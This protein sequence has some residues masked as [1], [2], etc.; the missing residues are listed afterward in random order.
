MKKIKIVIVLAF[1]GAGICFASTLS[2]GKE[3]ISL[4]L[5]VRAGEG[6][7]RLKPLV[8]DDFKLFIN[9]RPRG[10]AGVIEHRRSM[11]QPTGLGRNFILSFHIN[12]YG[13]KLA[14]GV[15]Y[16]VTEI[17]NNTDML[18]I[19]TPLKI[20][21]INV[22]RNKLKMLRD[23][24]TLVSRDCDI[25]NKDRIKFEKNL[26]TK[27]N[28]VRRV[29]VN[30]NDPP[31]PFAAISGFLKS[32]PKEFMDFTAHFLLPDIGKYRQA[33]DSLG[34]REGE[35]WCIH[36]Q[37]REV[38]SLFFKTR[39]IV[40]LI[41]TGFSSSSLKNLIRNNLEKLEKQLVLSGTELAQPFLETVLG[42]NINCSV[43]FFGSL[44]EKSSGSGQMGIFYPGEIL[45]RTA[46]GTGGKAVET[47]DPLQGVR[48]IRDHTD[49]CYELF[50]N[51]NGI[52]E[53]KRVRVALEDKNHALSYKKKF[54]KQEIESL[55]RYLS[56]EKVKI[57]DVM[58]KEGRRL[59]FSIESFKL[60]AY[61]RKKYGMLKVSIRL[62]DRWGESVYASG[63]TLRV[64]EKKV[65]VSHTFP[66]ENRGEYLL[67]I[68][69]TDLIRNSFVSIHRGIRL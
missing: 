55:V 41:K 52:I 36:F 63:R 47:M 61:K 65:K 43:V 64:S 67:I 24:E 62:H 25:Y 66:L 51:F 59:S 15:S 17:L 68:S 69:V 5:V 30:P 21:R 48:D 1:V 27:L 42:S 3:N 40:R 8:K 29:F 2:A 16:F 22:S 58:L 54:G 7:Y 18:F 53:E 13:K 33:I 10:I 11:G 37:Q 14:E 32:Y 28:E 35:R 44:N 57:V 4:S 6:N 19:I 46:V 9:D 49:H 38:Y 39:Q 50:F 12:E 34:E 20:Y 60:R 26:E 23:I 56:E 31:G 45:R